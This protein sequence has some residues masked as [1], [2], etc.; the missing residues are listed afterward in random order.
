MRKVS[1]HLVNVD[2]YTKR[3]FYALYFGHS[4][5]VAEYVKD[6]VL[7]HKCYIYNAYARASM[8]CKCFFV[9]FF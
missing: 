3:V 2:V 4:T 1:F 9:F 8:Y 5:M 6:G 7:N